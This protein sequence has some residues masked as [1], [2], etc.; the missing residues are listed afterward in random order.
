MNGIHEPRSS[1]VLRS[2][3]HIITRL[4]DE[5]PEGVEN[6][7]VEQVAFG[8]ALTVEFAPARQRRRGLSWRV[9]A[10]AF[11]FCMYSRPHPAQQD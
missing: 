1:R 2:A 7:A 3:K 8:A 4:D 9:Q 6:E 5:K 10:N 11:A